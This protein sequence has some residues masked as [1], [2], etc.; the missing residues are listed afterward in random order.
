MLDAAVPRRSPLGLV[1]AAAAFLL[2]VA[3]ST[4][5]SAGFWTVR[6]AVLLVIGA[7][8]LPFTVLILRTP[9]RPAA[10]AGLVFLGWAALSTAVAEHPVVTLLGRFNQ[11][12]GLLF[13]AALVGCWALGAV[14][15][16]GGRSAVEWGVIVGVLANCVVA[17]V[18]MLVD[19]SALHLDPLDQRARG[20][21]GNPVQLGAV[22]AGTFALIAPRVAR[23]ARPWPWAA[24]GLLLGA[25]LQLS[26]TRSALI[27]TVVV[28]VAAFFTQGWRPGAVLAGVLVAGLALGSLV[29]A[30]GSTAS[31]GATAAARAGEGSAGTSARIHTWRTALTAVGHRPLLGAGPGRFE[32]ATSPL[33]TL[34]IA[35]A[36]GPDRV[37]TDA[38]NLVVE[39]ATTT[40]VPGAIALLAF[41]ALA[42]LPGAG[43]R[44][45]FALAVLAV[46]LV[47]PQSVSSTPLA[48]LMLGAAL[49]VLEIPRRHWPT[50]AAASALATCAAAAGLAL[51]VGDWHLNQAN[52]DF[53]VAEARAADRWLS[54][55]PDPASQLAKTYVLHKQAG[56][57]EHWRLVAAQ[58]DPAQAGLWSDLGDL[59][60]ADG[61]SAEAEVHYRMALA[62]NPWSAQALN[63]MAR[64]KI[65]GGDHAAAVPFLRRSL[66]AM[67]NQPTI[68][69]LLTGP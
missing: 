63:G 37:F 59:E 62:R 27:V 20:A 36:E 30:V 19:L 69:G 16:E 56:P 55:Y 46:G 23:R 65:A 68:I 48:F 67:P 14:L 29:A 18:Q 5:L 6:A 57:A 11:G 31:A 47:E 28:V 22:A 33:R 8:G 34:A 13:V 41:V 35:R 26:G 61:R 12:T 10:V 49:P 64:A 25:A 45:A 60:L 17:V 9:A 4:N 44:R 2:L 38:H 51:I 50:L 40:G 54:P 58:R 53:T 43:S 52:L 66:L 3:F 15:P 24:A 42:A 1:T 32:E 39:Y 21:L 7:I